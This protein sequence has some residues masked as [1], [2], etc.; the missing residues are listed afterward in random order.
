MKPIDPRGKR[1]FNI[2]LTPEVSYLHLSTLFYA[3][4]VTMGLLTFVNI[5]QALILG[6]I[7]GGADLGK[8]GGLLTVTGELTIMSTVFLYGILCDR[9]GRRPVYALGLA[10]MGISYIL[11]PF[12]TS[13]TDLVIYRVIYAAGVAAATGMLG[14]I[15]NDYPQEMSRGKMVA[16][17]GIIIAI[18]AIAFNLMFR[19][20]LGSYEAQGLDDFT[21]SRN[22]HWIAAALCLGSAVLIGIGLKPGTPNTERPPPRD[23]FT[24]GFSEAL[25]LRTG[26]AYA[27]AF[28]ARS[29]LVI[30][31][32]FTALWGA[33]AALDRGM[34]PGEGVA[35][36][37][38]VFVVAQ[39]AGLLWAPV[40]GWAIDRFNR[41][42]VQAF[43]GLM[44]GVAFISML[45]VEDL[46]DNAYLP[47][48]CL[49]G[50]GQISIFYASQALIGQEAP[51]AKRGAVIG[52][53]GTCGAVGI[54]F[55]SGIGGYAFDA[56]QPAGAFFFV[57]LG[58]F[59]I[60]FL[61]LFVRLKAPGY[62]PSAPMKNAGVVIT[63]ST[64]GIGYGMA[65]EFLK[66]GNSVMITG[67][68]QEAV[69]RAVE[70]LTPV[71]ADG[72]K[73]AGMACDVREMRQLQDLW[74]KAR[75]SLGDID[76]WINN[77]GL[78]NSR[79]PIA[80]LPFRE[81]ESV[82][83][84]NL[85]G[86]FYGCKVALEGM[87]KQ[88]KGAIYN[89]EGFGSNGMQSPGSS[90]YGST[91]F[92]LRY[93]TKALVKE[94]RDES[95]LVGTISPGIVLTEMITRDKDVL[96]PQAWEPIKRVYNILADRVETVTPFLVDGVL[97]NRKHGGKVSW[98]T[99]RK[100]AWRFMK[101]RFGLGASRD[102]FAEREPRPA[103]Q[104][105]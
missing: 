24:S 10:L 73:V 76:I 71:A 22:V 34:S 17:S 66:R 83:H 69:D 97:R 50:I 80:R 19:G 78:N 47:L 101:A 49:L 16:L 95:V 4:L 96:P 81:M 62:T 30:I 20:L 35:R 87:R 23:L 37:L 32:T 72:A 102:L 54:L 67:R 14:T 27:S 63:G 75:E 70:S 44:S 89:F 25:K 57:G 99:R 51:S 38:T 58:A 9:V 8:R 12:A 79:M 29:D 5:G 39:V 52:A 40:M 48:F 6:G 3:S 88:G 61:G 94:T 55:F 68:T 31:G 53:F 91:K 105:R 41:V 103:E 74:V 90:I 93:F 100:S 98:L 1:F 13:V 65:R 2:W 85:L 104:G 59:V 21:A 28:V 56:W 36:A 42:S 82:P 33:Q 7:E 43:G 45:L 11:M 84:T 46:F 77:A 15:T 26:L 60:F 64:R 92:A 86:M 18:G